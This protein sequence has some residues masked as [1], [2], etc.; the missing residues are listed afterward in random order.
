MA[1]SI[2]DIHTR[3]G[4]FAIDERSDRKMARVLRGTTYP[5]DELIAFARH[6]TG[7]ESIALDIGAHIG[8]F[9]IPLSK[10]TLA[11]IAFEPVPQSFELLKRNCSQNGQT[12]D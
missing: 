2:T 8:T 12:I 6:F 5:N 10:F 9:A 11:V 1:N 7:P 3:Y 4:T